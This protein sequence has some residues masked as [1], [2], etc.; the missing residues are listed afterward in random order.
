[1]TTDNGMSDEDKLLYEQTKDVK[2]EKE[3]QQYD[4]VLQYNLPEGKDLTNY[5]PPST[6]SLI[7]FE[8]AI[9]QNQHEM[10][11]EWILDLTEEQQQ[12]FSDFNYD[13]IHHM[14]DVYRYTSNITEEEQSIKYTSK[15][16]TNRQRLKNWM[17]AF[18]SVWSTTDNKIEAEEK[19]R[20]FNWDEEYEKNLDEEYESRLFNA[21]NDSSKEADATAVLEND[22]LPNSETMGFFGKHWTAFSNQMSNDWKLARVL[23]NTFFEREDMPYTPDAYMLD[24]DLIRPESIRNPL[25]LMRM[26][27]A[28]ASSLITRGLTEGYRKRKH[29]KNKE[30]MSNNLTNSARG[31]ENAFIYSL[32]TAN[33]DAVKEQYPDFYNTIME[34]AQQDE[35]K[36]KAIV[37]SVAEANNPEFKATIAGGQ[38]AIAAS[39]VEGMKNIAKSQDTLGEL[40]VQGFGWWSKYVVGTISTSLFLLTDDEY[41]KMAFEF[42]DGYFERLH[43]QIKKADYSPAKVL[44]LDG[45]FGGSLIDIGTSFIFDPT[46]WF[47]APGVGLRAGKAATQ[48]A[49]KAGIKGWTSSHVGK[50]I[51]TTLWEVIRDS[52]VTKQV[53]VLAFNRFTHGFN[54]QS[55]AKLLSQV[56]MDVA[57]GLKKP[58]AA[59]FD[60]F[61]EALL[62]GDRPFNYHQNMWSQMKSR[63]KYTIVSKY[64]KLPNAKNAKTFDGLLTL[65]N[66]ST[67]VQLSGPHAR[68]NAMDTLYD[69]I[70]SSGTSVEF[71]DKLVRQVTKHLDK[72]QHNIGKYGTG[73]YGKSVAALKYKVMRDAELLN[74]LEIMLG[75]KPR[76]LTQGITDDVFRGQ[77]SVRNHTKLKDADGLDISHSGVDGMLNPKAIEEKIKRLKAE[78]PSLTDEVVV[79][80]QKAYIEKLEKILA[81]PELTE[82]AVTRGGREI[83]KKFGDTKPLKVDE[84]HEVLKNLI[85]ESKDLAKATDSAIDSK[86]LKELED[87][88]DVF[89][90]KLDSVQDVTL[91]AGMQ[92]GEVTAANFRKIFQ[93][94]H[95]KLQSRLGK[96]MMALRKELGRDYRTPIWKAV[97]DSIDELVVEMGWHKAPRFSGGWYKATTKLDADGLKVFDNVRKLKAK[98]QTDEAAVL[99]GLKPTEEAVY[100]ENPIQIKYTKAGKIKS[101]DIDWMKLRLMMNFKDDF[102]AAKY[103]LRGVGKGLMGPNKNISGRLRPTVNDRLHRDFTLIDGRKY[104]NSLVATVEKGLDLDSDEAINLM[105]LKGLKRTQKQL[106][107][108]ELPLS[109][110]E[111]S[112][113]NLDVSGTNGW[114]AWRRLSGSKVG[115]GM[116]T[117][118]QMHALEKVAKPK[119]AI[120]AASDEW[121]FLKSRYG[122]KG[123]KQDIVSNSQTRQIL[124]RVRKV[125]GYDNASP[126]LQRK[127]NKWVTE[128]LQDQQQLPRE[129]AARYQV[130]FNYKSADT[131]LKNTDPGFYEFAMQHVNGLLDDY[132]FR[133]YAQN[134]AP[135][136]DDIARGSRKGATKKQVEAKNIAEKKMKTGKDIEGWDEW[137]KTTDADYM[138]GTLI[139]KQDKIKGLKTTEGEPLYYGIDG[140]LTPPR[141]VGLMD[142]ADAW[143]IMDAQRIVYTAGNKGENANG[144]W[145]AFIDAGVKRAKGD[146]M[147]LPSDKWI[148]RMQ[149]VGKKGDPAGNISRM[150]GVPAMTGKD[151]KV[152]QAMFGNPAWN[153]T[154][155]IA[156]KAF[157][158]RRAVLIELM[159]SQGKKIVKDKDIGLNFIDDSRH[160]DPQYSQDMLGASYLDDDL[161]NKHN[162]ITE[163]WINAR[164]SEFAI[165]EVDDL[166]LKFHMSTPISKE[167]RNLVPFGDAWVDF[168]SRY[169]KDLTRRSQLKGNWLNYT[170]EATAGN[171]IKRGLNDAIAYLPNMRRLGYMSRISNAQLEGSIGGVDI[172]FSPMVFLPNGDNPMFALNPV[173]GMVPTLFLGLLIQNLEETEASEWAKHLED[174]F[175]STQ[176]VAPGSEFA[177]DP[178]GSTAKYLAGGGV[179]KSAFDSFIQPIWQSIPK[180][181]GPQ[182]LNDPVTALKY[183]RDEQEYL[184]KNVDLIV[185]SSFDTFYDY[186]SFLTEM[187]QG[188][189]TRAALQMGLSQT[190][191]L[192]VPVG[193]SLTADY[194]DLGKDWINAAESLNVLEDWTSKRT[195]TL[196][197]NHPWDEDVII[198]VQNEIKDSFFNATDA[199]RIL[200]LKENPGLIALSSAGY[201]VTEEG[202]DLLYQY[203]PDGK[204]K[205]G[206][207]FRTQSTTNKNNFPKYLAEGLIATKQPDDRIAEILYKNAALDVEAPEV[208]LKAILDK[209]NKWKVNINYSDERWEQ[210]IR[211]PFFQDVLG[212]SFGDDSVKSLEDTSAELKRAAFTREDLGPDV[213]KLLDEMLEGK[214]VPYDPEFGWQ[215]MNVIP[216][217]YASR[218]EAQANPAYLYFGDQTFSKGMQILSGLTK[219]SILFDN[220]DWERLEF[221]DAWMGKMFEAKAFK[222]DTGDI[223]RETQIELMQGFTI[224][225]HVMGDLGEGKDKDL[226][227]GQAWWDFFV[228]GDKHGLGFDIEWQTPLPVDGDIV[229]KELV[230]TM[231]EGENI[232]A[233][234]QTIEGKKPMFRSRQINAVSESVYDGDTILNINSD[235][236]VDSLRTIGIMANEMDLDPDIYPEEA[237]EAL[238]QRQFLRYLVDTYALDGKLY[239]ITDKRFG[240]EDH[241]DPYGRLVG[242]L[243]I[244]GGIDGQFAPGYGEYIFFANHF[245]PTDS[246]YARGGH[247][248][249][250]PEVL[251][252]PREIDESMQFWDLVNYTDVEDED[253]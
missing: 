152:M 67:K 53:D 9:T 162:V 153:R 111:F 186:E 14:G 180:R 40:V 117:A 196:Y 8:K 58:S 202:E 94:E 222:D 235:K 209:Q 233:S 44:G 159:E 116:T 33:L 204:Y 110:L 121:M 17:S 229:D 90:G 238:R 210:V 128:T 97:T 173:G 35:S 48:F 72:F 26:A 39:V 191:R 36:A 184:Y 149:V 38:E 144:L 49:T 88:V 220:Q 81:R 228:K 142:S 120:V 18:G 150:L 127:V 151:Q 27:G 225:N 68:Q 197:E 69:F 21:F 101:I 158:E 249:P 73:M 123:T 178:L 211:N 103:F 30:R 175:P 102:D 146:P 54:D 87:Y 74:A 164:A 66:T 163:G 217:L 169:M 85:N 23:G 213:S 143:K 42:G 181:K 232:T 34:V 105:R 139:Q 187:G 179:V 190:I 157:A 208:I 138:R 75:T 65:K 188:A 253:E 183:S 28:G 80:S 24:P 230:Y 7:P 12:E 10:P 215:A 147:A 244:D 166:M 70:Q 201:E 50:Y 193:V 16:K 219:S 56:E 182:P 248:E 119:T 199:Q 245:Q 22:V 109:P 241:R 130:S 112:I 124:R 59:F 99:K 170:D 51:G 160:I 57:R 195:L 86:M 1:M 108:G 71:Q 84:N 96:D 2:Y 79:G 239:F 20:N 212:Y 132:G 242:W 168:V 92:T 100:I 60:E 77:S 63:S 13:F 29:A 250:Y 45:H 37:L 6:G 154:N 98:H 55:T 118:A 141:W 189:R 218:K 194:V 145:R 137:F 203:E 91:Q 251:D 246:Y 231:D 136:L 131:L 148:G 78:L 172:D 19:L 155:L 113:I 240:N 247:L 89:Y 205:A 224:F 129:I 226:I 185:N 206:D 43:D 62:M 200:W 125:G 214:D 61:T 167:L 207:T 176:F 198:Q 11:N 5:Y 140:D 83:F 252:D 41:R 237:S 134:V 192:G 46:V 177:D 156:K 31:Q 135:L 76:V 106:V 165:N 223:P 126:E 52:R 15:S 227:T 104:D 25:L 234:F 174:I 4:G 243:F 47:F 114:Q 236:N 32:G 93:K 122:W 64:A 3:D 133:V 216:Y 107:N 82:E 221:M 161:Y 115:E 171:K 95:R